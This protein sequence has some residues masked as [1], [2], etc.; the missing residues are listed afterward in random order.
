VNT[1]RDDDL[2]L[3]SQ[4]TQ[5]YSQLDNEQ[6]RP[7][8]NHLKSIRSETKPQWLDAQGTQLT[9]NDMARLSGVSFATY[10]D[11]EGRKGWFNKK[12]ANR[13]NR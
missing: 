9:L 4:N 5:V 10:Q 2:N 1:H 6:R 12:H 8:A 11:W 3:N 13:E 7:I